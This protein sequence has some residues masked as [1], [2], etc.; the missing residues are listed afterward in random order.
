[1]NMYSKRIRSSCAYNKRN[2]NIVKFV[3]KMFGLISCLHKCDT[4]SAEYPVLLRTCMKQKK[5][6]EYTCLLYHTK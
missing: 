1:M 2:W 4:A 3:F 6:A 5:R